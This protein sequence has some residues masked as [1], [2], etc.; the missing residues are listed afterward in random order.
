MRFF[1]PQDAPPHDAAS[2]PPTEA[3]LLMIK[4]R[5]FAL[6]YYLL[7]IPGLLLMFVFAPLLLFWFIWLRVRGKKGTR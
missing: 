4:P 6:R 3:E 2:P 1:P 7:S 5:P